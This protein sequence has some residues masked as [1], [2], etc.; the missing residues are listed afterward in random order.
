MCEWPPRCTRSCGA[1]CRCRLQS[2]DHLVGAI[3]DR[4]RYFHAKCLSSLEIDDEFELGRPHDRKIGGLRAREDSAGI[5]TR[6]MM[7]FGD[8]ASIADQAAADCELAKQEAG[9]NPVAE[10]QPGQLPKLPACRLWQS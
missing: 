5:D 9:G 3:E 6:E 7:R 8:T 10:R 2:L 1:W 4:R